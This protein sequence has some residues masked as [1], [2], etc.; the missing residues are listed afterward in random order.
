MTLAKA[1][2]ETWASRSKKREDALIEREVACEE[3]EANA[4]KEREDAVTVRE[5]VLAEAEKVAKRMQ[6]EASKAKTTYETL[7]ADINALQRRAPK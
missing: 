4:F 7:I 6:A 2:A 5:G 3:R 1:N